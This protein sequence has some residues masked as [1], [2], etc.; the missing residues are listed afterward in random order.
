MKFDSVIFLLDHRMAALRPGK[1]PVFISLEKFP[2]IP[3]IPSNNNMEESGPAQEELRRVLRPLVKGF[4]RKQAILLCMP[5]DA[6]VYVDQKYV[7]E[8]F[9]CRGAGTNTT[10]RTMES[11][12][13]AEEK[14]YVA[15][16]RS[17]RLLTMTYRRGQSQPKR[18]HL[19]LALA[20]PEA[21]KQG[22]RNLAPEVEYNQPDIYIL[23]PDE[24]LEE[25]YELGRPVGLAELA[26][27]A[28]RLAE[29]N[30]L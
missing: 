11:L 27:F 21:V 4:F 23:D 30:W 16:S 8:F 14:E 28:F 18:A 12:C 26:G 6:T 9:I 20:G 24:R 13:L 25:Y 22:I 3:M 7:R 17:E 29:G 10:V 19:P 15:V 5:D 2:K 1:Q